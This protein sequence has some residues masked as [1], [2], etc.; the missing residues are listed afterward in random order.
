MLATIQTKVS[1]IEAQPRSSLDLQRFR[2]YLLLLARSHDQMGG[3]EAS[4]IV[5]KTMLAAHAQRAE[6]RGQSPA[7]LAA[8]LK[9]ILRREVIDAYRQRRRLKRDVR[10][11]VPLEAEVDGSFS[12]A[13]VWLAAAQ[14]SPS[15]LVSRE[16]ELVA[17]ADALAQLPEAQRE[18]V[19]LHHLQG[20]SLAEVAAQ[21]QR[22]EAAV[23]GLLHR[24][25]KQ[26]RQI[27]DQPSSP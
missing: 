26:L 21:L 2:T 18:A 12:R 4:D 7:E 24:G 25:L 11:E 19:V 14:T 9:Q 16:E 5:Q 6:F 17:M 8:W 15:Q 27:L 1:A 3:E 23:A 10:R 13:Q 20:A 22:T